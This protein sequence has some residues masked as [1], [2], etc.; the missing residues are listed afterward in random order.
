ME[1]EYGVAGA[2]I[3]HFCHRGKPLWMAGKTGD[4]NDGPGAGCNMVHIIY[5]Y[6]YHPLAILCNAHQYTPWTVPF[7]QEL[8]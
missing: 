2:H 4:G 7:L 1:G 8:Y 6:S 5:Y 3:D